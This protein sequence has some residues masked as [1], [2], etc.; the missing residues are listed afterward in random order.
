MICAW[1]ICQRNGLC[2]HLMKWLSM[3]KICSLQGSIDSS[4]VFTPGDAGLNHERK[5]S[6]NNVGNLKVVAKVMDG[7]NA[8]ESDAHLLV[9]VP[10]F[11][12]RGDSVIVV[13][14][15]T[16]NNRLLRKTW[17]NNKKRG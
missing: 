8:V 16:A 1:V 6:T 2:S 12:K 3:I 17:T 5:F 11:I 14:I 7:D 10:T 9:T 15:T 4:G 13:L